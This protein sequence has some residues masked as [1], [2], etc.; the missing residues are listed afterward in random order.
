MRAQTIPSCNLIMMALPPIP[1]AADR[2]PV[3]CDAYMHDV[4]SIMQ[5]LPPTVLVEAGLNETYTFSP[6][7]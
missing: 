3:A 2:T 5:G 6:E 7:I 1:E 4:Y